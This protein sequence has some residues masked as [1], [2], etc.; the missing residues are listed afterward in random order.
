MKKICIS[1]CWHKPLIHTPTFD[2]IRAFLIE[3]N[4]SRVS[5]V[6]LPA[7]CVPLVPTGRCP[8]PCQPLEI[9]AFLFSVE[10]AQELTTVLP[11]ES[12]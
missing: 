5:L 11:L 10:N 9:A 3:A 7:L 8:D 6:S 2:G 1:G 12:A 4:F